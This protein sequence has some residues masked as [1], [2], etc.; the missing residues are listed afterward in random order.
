M[1]TTNFIIALVFAGLFGSAFILLAL[2][3]IH[4]YV[5]RCCLD[6][7]HWFQALFSHVS[8]PPPVVYVEKQER[9]HSKHRSQSRRSE[10]ERRV[11]RWQ[12]PRYHGN[13][14]RGYEQT[15]KQ[16]VEWP[17]QRDVEMARSP[18]QLSAPL[19]PQ[20]LPYGQSYHPPLGWPDQA[21][22]MQP[23]GAHPAVP[24]AMQSAIP[25]PPLPQIAI[26]MAGPVQYPPRYQPQRGSLDWQP[27]HEPGG[28]GA[29][30][31]NQHKSSSAKASSA[32]K[33]ARRAEKVDYI[34]ICDEYPPMVLEALRKAAP[35]SPTSSS[36]PSSSDVSGTTQEVPRTSV[37]CATPNLAKNSRLSP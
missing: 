12:T 10:R 31:A 5:H 25:Q 9:S 18:M 4:S 37:P 34:H 14:G 2:W 26:N 17:R 1:T 8:R 7:E 11:E 32:A 22:N 6:I 33:Q 15:R 24:F 27:Y 3:C 23:Q 20:Q 30:I 13:W 21:R 29:A 35:R 16:N 36:S 19:Q 28:S